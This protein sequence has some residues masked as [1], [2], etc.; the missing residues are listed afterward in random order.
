MNFILFNPDEM[1]AESVGC[2]GHPVS[3]TPHMDRLAAEG[4]RFE[5]CHVQHT[6]CSPS[7]CSFMTGW[8]PHVR[9]HR[10]LW[11]LLRPDEPNLLRYLK[12]AGYDVQ[13]WGKNDLLAPETFAG[14]VNRAGRP[15]G[16]PPLPG[17]TPARTNPF[18]PGTPGFYS[19][20]YEPVGNAPA[21]NL[22]DFR[23]VQAAIDYL[24]A[25]PRGPFA[26]FLPIGL[27]HC[28][29][30]AP[31]PWHDLIDPESLPPL[32]PVEPSAKPDFH[33]LIREYRDLE[34]LDDAFFR[35]I[36]A[37]YLGMISLVD[38]MLGRL[39]EALEES[40]H[41]DDTTVI[42]FSDHGDWAGDYGLVEKWPSGLDDCLTRVPLIVRSPDNQAGHEAAGPV[43]AFDIMAT[44]LELAGIE[45]HHT[46]FARSLVPELNGDPG[47][48]DRA[49][50]AEGGY[51]PHEPHCFEGYGPR[52]ETIMTPGHI[53]YPKLLQQQEHPE[54]VCR[55][56]MLRTATHKLVRR[57]TGQHELYDLTRDPRELNNVYGAAEYAQVCR[58]L[59]QR[60][61]DWYLWTSDVVPPDEDPRGFPAPA[62]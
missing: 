24:R 40:G 21:E 60:L 25:G 58:R 47:D 22:G 53:Y 11:H 26:L 8:Y 41:A 54:S 61:M 55:A 19:F 5:Q 23:C 3:Q 28:P 42:V 44:V 48:P 51:D 2:Y 50:F 34:V 17:G 10:T 18:P 16:P 37:V 49:V 57:S 13:W 15:T 35:K 52:S 43:E 33:R 9:G 59:E 1:R 12:D 20:L 32:R 56:V 45:P 29:Y 62:T 39:L 46:H 4:V 36:N 6:V 7:R 14:S 38:H 31:R 30:V 27:P